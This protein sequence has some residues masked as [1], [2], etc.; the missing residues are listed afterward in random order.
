MADWPDTDH[1]CWHW[2]YAR[3]LHP[4]YASV[5]SHLG[6]DLL[7]GPG[8]LPQD[9]HHA[10][11]FDQPPAS[12]L[13]LHYSRPFLDLHPDF[14]P[15]HLVQLAEAILEPYQK[16]ETQ[17]YREQ[18]ST[19][20]Q[21]HLLQQYQRCPSDH[22]PH[23]LHRHLGHHSTVYWSDCR[24]LDQFEEESSAASRYCRMRSRSLRCFAQATPGSA[25]AE[26]IG[27]REAEVVRRLCLVLDQQK[28]D[29]SYCWAIQRLSQAAGIDQS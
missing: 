19:I 8:L 15:L 7:P 23:L 1:Q 12:H 2:W 28:Q 27:L 3:G 10:Q 9:L 26:R 25:A 22:L 16:E 17:W 20:P 21:L 24:W 5:S 29:W 6:S 13:N 14:R 11:A 18:S 4:D